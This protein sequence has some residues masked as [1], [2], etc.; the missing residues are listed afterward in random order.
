MYMGMIFETMRAHLTHIPDRPTGDR[1]G[2][3]ETREECP[4]CFLSLGSF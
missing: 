4:G 2:L 1:F 3:E